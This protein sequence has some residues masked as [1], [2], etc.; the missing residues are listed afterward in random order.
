MRSGNELGE[1]V[2]AQQAVDLDDVLGLG[3]QGRGDEALQLLRHG[4]LDLDPD[5][6]AQ[7]TLLE[8]QFELADQVL[9]LFL[10]FHV[11]I[12]DQAEDP[13]GLDFAAGEQVVQEE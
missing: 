6:A 12:A 5:H 9:G 11:G 1:L 10:D 2:Q 8:R 7:A 13:L 4:G 3:V